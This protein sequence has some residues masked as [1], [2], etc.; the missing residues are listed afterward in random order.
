MKSTIKAV[1]VTTKKET[2]KYTIYEVTCPDGIKYD[3]FDK[4]V[5]GQQY[6]GTITPNEN[7]L[8]NS[9]FKI[10]KPAN[11][12]FAPKDYT[13]EKRKVALECA[14][15]LCAAGHLH[16]DSI[17]STADVFIKYLNGK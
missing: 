5:E 2:D 14:V 9:K 15:S 7:P 8:Y 4:I 13:F 1:R 12:K 16:K 3:T 6:E 10:D 11:S 17:E